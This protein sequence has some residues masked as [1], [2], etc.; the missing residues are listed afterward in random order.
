MSESSLSR[1]WNASA[2]PWFLAVV[3]TLRTTQRS[4]SLSVLASSTTVVA[5]TLRKATRLSVTTSRFSSTQALHCSIRA[6]SGWYTTSWFRRPRSTCVKCALSTQSGC[7]K[8]LLSSSKK[9]TPSRSASARDKKSWSHS[10]TGTRILTLGDLPADAAD[11]HS[12]CSQYSSLR[13]INKSQ[14]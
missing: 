3:S 14:P 12:N 13:S 10:S 9:A 8:S 11:S 4:E 1:S 5:R 7:S 2:Y 6:P